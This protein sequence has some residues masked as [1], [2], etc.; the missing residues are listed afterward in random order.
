[1]IKL[2]PIISPDPTI[3]AAYRRMRFAGES[4]KI[5]EMLAFRKGPR[6]ETDST[7]MAGSLNEPFGSQGD[8]PLT[9][10][11]Y[12]AEAKRAK[13]STEGKKY[14]SGLAR[15]PGDPKAW[16]TGRGDVRRVCEERGWE[17]TGSVKVK[18]G[19]KKLKRRKA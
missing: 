8:H 2:L 5:A 15:F 16:V 7:F 17:C 4:H 1:M 3:Q 11:R 13:I 12:K 6:I 10:A 19:P 14:L 18:A 9:V